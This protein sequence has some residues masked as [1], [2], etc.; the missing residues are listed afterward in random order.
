[1]T[2][3][4]HATAQRTTRTAVFA[5]KRANRQCVMTLPDQPAHLSPIIAGAWRLA[6][7]QWTPQQRLAW[8]EGHLDLGVTSVDLA[9]IDGRAG[10][11]ALFG[12]ALTLRPAL[13]HRL[14]LVGTCVL[15]PGAAVDV[16]VQAGVERSLRALHTDH[17]D[18]LLL[19]RPDPA[20]DLDALAAAFGRLRAAGRVRQFGLGQATPALL[21][22]LQARL[23]LAAHQV[24][25]SPL[26][27][28]ALHDGTLDQCQALGLRPMAW[29]PLAGGRIFTGLDTAACR[30]RQV[31]QTVAAERGIAVTTLVI[32]WVR[33]HPSRP[34]PILGSRRA[35][36]AQEALAA[37]DFQLDDATWRSIED[38]AAPAADA[39]GRLP[40][41]GVQAGDG[42]S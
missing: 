18:L 10:T 28:A 21:A 5:S 40:L 25:L 8:I 7:W 41:V 2:D 6:D 14:Q 19:H 22:G 3:A 36:V 17:L 32:A 42:L 37:L 4:I 26:Q 33:R 11:E 35:S 30:L 15:A 13:R 27:P 34:L 24:T 39:N 12:E 20:L 29:A 16:Q 1:M 31:L 23:P 9:D 38:A